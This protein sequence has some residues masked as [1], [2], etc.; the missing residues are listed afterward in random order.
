VR[1]LVFSDLN[2]PPG[3]QFQLQ[4][5]PIT[6]KTFTAATTSIDHDGQTDRLAM[7]F[8]VSGKVQLTDN[9]QAKSLPFTKRITYWMVPASN[10]TPGQHSWLIDGWDTKYTP[11]K[12]VPEN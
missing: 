11:G 10:T 7:S 2:G 3:S 1:F 12:S 8:S 4:T 5:E 6:D 9:G